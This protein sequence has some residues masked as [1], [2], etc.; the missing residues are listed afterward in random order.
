MA[1]WDNDRSMLEPA[2]DEL[3]E[4]LEWKSGGSASNE[5]V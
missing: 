4:V 2:M 1:A 3:R 5:T